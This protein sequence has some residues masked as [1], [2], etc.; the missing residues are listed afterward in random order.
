MYNAMIME[1]CNGGKGRPHEVGGVGLVVVTLS[2]NA[3]KQL[4]SKCKIGY[5][6]DCGAVSFAPVREL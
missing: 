5:Q 4:A 2:T 1:I 6:V 3:V